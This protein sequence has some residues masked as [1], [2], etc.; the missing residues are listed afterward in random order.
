[1]S[2]MTIEPMT[3]MFIFETGQLLEQ[4]EQIVLAGEKIKEFT[5]QDI[6][7]IFRI[8]HTIKCSSAM[9]LYNNISTLTH[10]NGD[11]SLILDMAQLAGFE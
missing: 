3:E 11:I 1:M 9:I 2:G 6:N 8:M 5:S 10:C 4:R 7:E